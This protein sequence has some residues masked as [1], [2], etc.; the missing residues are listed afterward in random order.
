MSLENKMLAKLGN[1]YSVKTIDTGTVI[2]RRLSSHEF[3]IVVESA[4]TCSVYV[5]RCDPRILEGVYHK[6]PTEHLSD[7]L[8]YLAVLYQKLLPLCQ[9]EREDLTE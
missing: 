2:Y 7:Y 5:W 6:V 4:T 1:K 8:G 9:V 3:E